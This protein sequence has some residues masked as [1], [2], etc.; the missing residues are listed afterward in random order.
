[1]LPIRQS[2]DPVLSGIAKPVNNIDKSIR[3]L[4]IHMEEA[5]NNAKD[6]EGVGLAA[7]QVGKPYRVFIVKESKNSPLLTFIN[8]ELELSKSLPIAKPKKGKKKDDLVKLEGCL[9]LQDIWGIVNRYDTVKLSYMDETGKKH[10]REK[11]TGFLATII[12]HEVDH[13]NGILFPKRV[14]EQHNKLYKSS[15][16]KKGET[17]FEEITI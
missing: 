16:N 8:P 9:S 6:P 14:L 5:L 2:P 4:L 12:Q 15:K 13:L 17:V 3:E 7:P 10:D 1:M 11:F